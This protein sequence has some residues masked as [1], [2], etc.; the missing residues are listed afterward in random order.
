[1]LLL[2]CGF[3]SRCATKWTLYLQVSFHKKT[4][5]IQKTLDLFL[6]SSSIKKQSWNKIVTWLYL[7]CAITLLWY[8][9][10]KTHHYVVRKKRPKKISCWTIINWD[11]YEYSVF[12]SFFR[13]YAYSPYTQRILLNR[14]YNLKNP[15]F[16][17]WKYPSGVLFLRIGG[18]HLQIFS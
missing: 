14:V 1:M 16:H 15:S 13:H 12:P 17:T 2:N 3:C 9:H 6:L 4:N 7:S 5:I 18:E 11:V 8:N 10:C